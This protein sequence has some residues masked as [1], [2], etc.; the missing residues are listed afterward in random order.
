MSVVLSEVDVVNKWFWVIWSNGRI[1][2]HF[3][4]YWCGCFDA[5]PFDNVDYCFRF[6]S[7]WI[8]YMFMVVGTFGDSLPVGVNCSW[9]Q[10]N[11][12]FPVTFVASI[13]L[14]PVLVTVRLFTTAHRRTP[15]NT[16][17]RIKIITEHLKV[18][19]EHIFFITL[20][21][22]SCW[23]T[24]FYHKSSRNGRR[25]LLFYHNVH[26]FTE[27]NLTAEHFLLQPIE[28]ILCKKTT[29]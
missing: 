17:E 25:T 10:R 21:E 2:L 18:T 1:F 4:G 26:I 9:T 7:C 14:N 29:I 27:L 8:W 11:Y 3:G 20:R 16:T 12:A 23:E 13:I 24:K 22:V 28:L 19:T 6:Y 15:K 5:A